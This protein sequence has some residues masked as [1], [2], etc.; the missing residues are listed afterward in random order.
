M[1]PSRA[2]VP[3][4]LEIEEEYLA[5]LNLAHCELRALQLQDPESRE[6]GYP[7]ML[8]AAELR[9]RAAMACFQWAVEAHRGPRWI[10]LGPPI[11]ASPT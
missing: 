6:A 4:R 1:A 10:T 3:A 11:S 5:L 7:A 2:R 9:Y 8:G